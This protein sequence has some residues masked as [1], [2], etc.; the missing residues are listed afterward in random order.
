M[1]STISLCVLQ[2]VAFW[3]S[4]YNDNWIEQKAPGGLEK[5]ILLF[6]FFCPDKIEILG[7]IEGLLDCY[8]FL[9]GGGEK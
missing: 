8:D 9:E 2:I 5:N 1:K 4:V 7:N 3:C 6:F